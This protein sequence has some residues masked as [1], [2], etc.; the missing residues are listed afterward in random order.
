M[1]SDVIN[2]IREILRKEGI[3]GKDSI[4]YC[5]GFII[6]RLL[7]RKLCQ[8]L[9][10]DIKYAY[11]NF[12]KDS[13]K[14][15][16]LNEL[17]EKFYNPGSEDFLVLELVNKLNMDFLR[18]F[19]IKSTENLKDILLLM[20]DL[21]V[22]NLNEKYDL[23]GIIYELHLKTGA[24]GS[25]MRDLGQFFTN[26]QVIEY[27]IKLCDPKI[28]DGKI[29][30]ICDPTMGTGGFLTMSI[31]YLNSKNSNINWEL[32]KE[33]VYGFDIDNDVKNLSVLNLLLE[34]G[35]KFNNLQQQDT[36]RNDLKLSSNGMILDKVKIILANEPMGIKID[37]SECCSRIKNLKLK[38]KKAEPLFMQLF[39]E[40]LDIDGRACVIVPNGFLFGL[41]SLHT[42]T[43][44]RLIENFDLKK[45]IIL[46]GDYFLNT[47]VKTSIIYFENN[48]RRTSVV[49]FSELVDDNDILVEN[50]LLDV[51]YEKLVEMKYNLFYEIYSVDNRD[52]FDNIEY[53]KIKDCCNFLPGSK[54]NA[55]FGQDSGKY[56]FFTSSM[57]IKY[58]DVADYNVESV[59]I[60]NGGKA[61]VKYGTNF[62]CSGHNIIICSKHNEISIKYI[63]YYL[64]N[65]LDILERGFHG[66]TINNVSKDFIGDLEI[67]IPSLKT[68][69]KIIRLLD[70]LTQANEATKYSIGAY[71]RQS[72][73][74][75]DVIIKNSQKE[76]LGDICSFIK[77]KN[78][79]KASDGKEKGSYK[80]IVS[81]QDKILFRDDYEFEDYYLILGSGGNSSVHFF[82]QF[83]ASQDVFIMNTNN[84]DK[85]LLKYIYYYLK[86]NIELL[87]KGFKGTTIQHTNQKYIQGLEIPI[88]TQIQQQYLIN[89]CDR[90]AYLI[91]QLKYNLELTNQLMKCILEQE[92]QNNTKE[93][94]TDL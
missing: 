38:G 37:Y 2:R 70:D 32:N 76:K 49:E 40:S 92:L 16:S 78:K 79:Y 86:N 77:K 74:L 44:K 72:K 25:G 91:E 26:R 1:F 59:I 81:S 12:F 63:Y 64:L 15:L 10:I 84:N 48:G 7:D 90:L 4:N 82:K 21:D 80:F 39:M 93:T 30:S 24:S 54:K 61:N 13:N 57:N 85:S 71:T 56:P 52:K 45:V 73:Y 67:P 69:N 41:D 31:K 42:G 27:M 65:N 68:Q 43:R 3:T 6:C 34:T 14:E 35:S 47:G 36:L 46:K 8:R 58:C 55:S 50:K 75:I 87:D 19:K 18:G 29:E 66:S 23:I 33:F 28:I 83:S 62:S 53:H 11:D 88:V 20:R 5:I 22:N 51:S 60:G 17:Y 89:E 9:N 94:I